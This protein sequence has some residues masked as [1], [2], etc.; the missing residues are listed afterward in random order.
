M[1]TGELKEELKHFV[2]LNDSVSNSALTITNDG[3]TMKLMNSK[4]TER[5]RQQGTFTFYK[6]VP[7]GGGSAV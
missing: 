4:S 5:V 1:F 3:T 7:E 2:H 6:F